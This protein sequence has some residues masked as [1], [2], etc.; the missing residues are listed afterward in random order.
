METVDD[1]FRDAAVDFIRRQHDADTPFFVWFNSTH[2]HFR[3]HGKPE[4]RGRAGRWQSEYHDTMLDHDDIVGSVA[5]L[6]DE[7][8]LAE[9]TIVMYSTDNGPHMNTWPDAGHDPVPQR[10]ELQLGRAPTACRRGPLARAHPRRHSA[11]RHREPQ[12]LVRHP[13]GRRRRPRHRRAAEGGHRSERHHLQG[14]PRRSQ[15][16]AVHHRRDRRRARAS[17]SSTSPTTATSRRCATTTGRSCSSSSGLAGTLRSGPSRTPSCGSR[18]S[19]TSAP[20]RTSGPTSRR[21][22]TTTGCSITPGF[23]VP[24]QAYVAQM[25][26]TL[27]EFPAAPEARQLQLRPGDG[28]APGRRR[29][30]VTTEPK[31]SPTPTTRRL[32]RGG[33]FTMGSDGHYPEEAPAHRVAVDA[34]WIDRRQVTNAAVRRVRGRDRATSPSPSGRSTRP[35]S[36]ARRPE[37]LVPGSLVF[38]PTPGRSTCATSASGGRGPRARRGDTRKARRSVAELGPPGRARR[39]R[40]R[41]GLR[42]GPAPRCPT[43]AEW[44]HAARGGLD[45]AAFTW[46]DEPRPGGRD[47]GEH[48]GWCRLPWRSTGESGCAAHVAGRLVPAE[49]LRALRHGRQRLGVDRRLVD[50]RHPADADT[51]RAARPTTRGGGADGAELDPA[52][53]QFRSRA[54]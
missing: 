31:A 51:S 20:I 11:Q 12:R 26:Q 37:N 33:S 30:R 54:R 15:P 24:A 46:G 29:Q 50:D 6:L 17:T 42:G 14:A 25:L 18:R 47:H 4:S 40:G 2:M 34:F 5:R 35:T 44:E 32:D 41:R 28:E 27:A 53:P 49:R 23:C 7:L 13:A 19:S 43:E 16:T 22:P 21:T 48:L 10:E 36:P 3:T 9:D 39:P 1:E 45:G 8:G 38:T 52:Q